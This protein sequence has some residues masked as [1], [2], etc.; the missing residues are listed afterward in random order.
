MTELAPKERRL[1]SVLLNADIAKGM[2][3]TGWSSSNAVYKCVDGI[4]AGS[5]LKHID[6][7]HLYDAVVLIV[8]HESFDPVPDGQHIPSLMPSFRVDYFSPKFPYWTRHTEPQYDV[9][10][11]TP[12]ASHDEFQAKLRRLYATDGFK[13]LAFGYNAVSLED[14]TD[15]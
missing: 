5:K 13:V 14:K 3:T 15:E 4:P 8:E 12:V 10:I 2:L 11:L 7:D 6:Y 1:R 9:P